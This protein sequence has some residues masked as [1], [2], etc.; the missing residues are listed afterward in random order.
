[1]HGR[2]E[3][4]YADNSRPNFAESLS[5]VETGDGVGYLADVPSNPRPVPFE[6][7]EVSDTRAVFRNTDHDF[8]KQLVYTLRDECQLEIAVSDLAERGFTL[9][10]TRA[11]PA[12]TN[13]A[14]R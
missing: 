7:T 14:A 12:C 6:L 1:M 5:L 2:G 11:S 3:T 8:P 13:A 4:R 10:L 9:S